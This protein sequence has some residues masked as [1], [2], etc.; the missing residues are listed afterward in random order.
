MAPVFVSVRSLVAGVARDC[1]SRLVFCR[2]QTCFC[3]CARSER[4]RARARSSESS[5][6]WRH[7]MTPVVTVVAARMAIVTWRRRDIPEKWPVIG[8]AAIL[9]TNQRGGN[10]KSAFAPVGESLR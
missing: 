10:S 2:S 6:L 7:A 4:S 1:S 5:L 9:L 3:N 8:P